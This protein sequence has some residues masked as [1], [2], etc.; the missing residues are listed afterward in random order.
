MTTHLGSLKRVAG[1]VPG[2]VNGS[3]EFDLDDADVALS[4]SSPGIPGASHALVGGG[5]PGIPARR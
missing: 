3:L 4:G 5:A 2:V 1:E